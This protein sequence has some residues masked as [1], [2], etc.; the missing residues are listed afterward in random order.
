MNVLISPY[1]G[2]RY[3]YNLGVITISIDKK[4]LFKYLSH[5]C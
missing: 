1:K 5:V 3:R 2:I 4:D